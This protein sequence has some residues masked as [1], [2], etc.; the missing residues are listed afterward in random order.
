MLLA[1]I[2]RYTGM[3]TEDNEAMEREKELLERAKDDVQVTVSE[4]NKRVSEEDLN[5]LLTD[6]KTHLS[7]HDFLKGKLILTE[8]LTILYMNISNIQNSVATADS[9][10][11]R[12]REVKSRLE[13]DKVIHYGTGKVNEIMSGKSTD[14]TFVLFEDS[15]VFFKINNLNG[16]KVE[17]PI[18]TSLLNSFH[19]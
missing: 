16:H 4:I 13:M 7:I 8:N 17:Y 1:Q 10:W 2:L 5:G 19:F 12:F 3:Q 14:V 6:I 9:L 15:F 11:G 18:E